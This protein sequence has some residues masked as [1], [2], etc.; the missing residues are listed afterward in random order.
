MTLLLTPMG[1]FPICSL[2]L[3]AAMISFFQV[4]SVWADKRKNGNTILIV[5]GI[6]LALVGIA[7]M[8]FLVVSPTY[9]NRHDIQ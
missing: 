3:F 6:I 7:M 2:V 5:A 4:N 1:W 8:Y 9:V